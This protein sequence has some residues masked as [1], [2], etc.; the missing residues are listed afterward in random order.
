MKMKF[1]IGKNR[2]NKNEG[3][4]EDLKI[5]KRSEFLAEFR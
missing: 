5:K 3:M 4:L 2:L 1:F